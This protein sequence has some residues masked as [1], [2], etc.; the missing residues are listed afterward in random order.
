MGAGSAPEV[1]NGEVGYIRHFSANLCQRNGQGAFL[2][3]GIMRFCIFL[4]NTHLL[5]HENVRSSRSHSTAG[6]GNGMSNIAVFAAFF[7]QCQIAPSSRTLPSG[8]RIT[9]FYDTHKVEQLEG[10]SFWRLNPL[11]VAWPETV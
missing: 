7:W 3:M 10:S 8:R 5:L 6:D 4:A 2:N 9:P 11:A 1:V